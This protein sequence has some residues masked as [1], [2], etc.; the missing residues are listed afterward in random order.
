MVVLYYMY[1]SWGFSII[2]QGS[3]KVKQF[4]IHTF[5]GCFMAQIVDLEKKIFK[6]FLYIF[7]C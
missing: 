4:R 6:H 1:I 7:L 5:W 3:I 2:V